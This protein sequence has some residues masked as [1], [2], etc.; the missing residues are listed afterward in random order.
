MSVSTNT[1]LRTRLRQATWDALLDAAAVV[2]ARDGAAV[3]IEDVAA[4][5]GVAVGTVY[6]YFADRTEL[7]RAV[8]ES[9]TKGLLADLDA[10]VQ[11]A[12]SGTAGFEQALTRFVEAMIQH[13]EANR[14]LIAA[15]LDEQ[16]QHGM[17]AKAVSHRESKFEQILARAEVLMSKGLKA[18]ALRK[19]EPAVY[20]AL[21]L[22]MFR[23]LVMGSLAKHGA[24]VS[25]HAG[26]IVEMFLKGAGR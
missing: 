14:V 13:V 1:P 21:L 17:D 4:E 10:V 24:K 23:G 15:I 25:P 6:N 18:Q 19:G 26:T 2:F 3:R 12:E 9:R 20:A 11:S 5:A 22:G 16:L 7:I 8:L